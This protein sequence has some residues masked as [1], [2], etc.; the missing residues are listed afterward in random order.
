MLAN[1]VAIAARRA[2]GYVQS[3][4]HNEWTLDS[5]QL[6]ATGLHDAHT[7]MHHTLMDM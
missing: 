6:T 1:A 4:T 7:H 3:C 5:T 2:G